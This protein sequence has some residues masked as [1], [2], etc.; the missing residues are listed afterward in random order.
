MP[1][2]R[3][4]AQSSNQAEARSRVVATHGTGPTRTRAEPYGATSSPSDVVSVLAVPGDRRP[5]PLPQPDAGLPPQVGEHAHV[6]ELLGGP[7]RLRPVP[8]G[9]P[10]VARLLGEHPGDLP[11][12]H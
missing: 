9:L 1:P 8:P 7:V 3:A 6:E 12:R 11:E 10:A 5:D 2:R 4:I